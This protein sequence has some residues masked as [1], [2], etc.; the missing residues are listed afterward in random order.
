MRIDLHTHILPENLPDLVQRYG[1][2]GF[3]RLDHY[4]PCRA[5]MMINGQNFRE[6]QDNC[7]DPRRRIEECDERGVDVQVLPA[8]PVMFSYWA[9][10]AD[11]LDLARLLNDHIAGVVA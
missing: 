7:W 6:I 10:P 2:E 3:V 1:Y 11:G 9:R 8:G 4:A 5:R